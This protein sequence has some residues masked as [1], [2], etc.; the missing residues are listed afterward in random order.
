VLPILDRSKNANNSLQQLQTPST[1]A[2]LSLSA[3]ALI[4]SYAALIQAIETKQYYNAVKDMRPGQTIYIQDIYAKVLSGLFMQDVY[5]QI[6]LDANWN[7]TWE[8]VI[9][10]GV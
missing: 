6:S 5:L 9:Q 2:V 3:K 7:L 1:G 10:T 8:Y 4:F